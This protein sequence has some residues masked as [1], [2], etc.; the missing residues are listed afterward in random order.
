MA[1]SGTT[2]EKVA[3]THSHPR[4][5][6]ELS[7]APEQRGLYLGEIS[8]SV[9]HGALTHSFTILEERPFHSVEGATPG[10]LASQFCQE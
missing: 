2:K 8:I 10:P 7:S 4:A 5:R 1:H 3:K 9:M 6:G